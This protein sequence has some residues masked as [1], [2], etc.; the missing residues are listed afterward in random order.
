MAPPSSPPSAHRGLS[1]QLLNS[2]RAVAGF[3]FSSSVRGST[4]CCRSRL[5][6]SPVPTLCTPVEAGSQAHAIDFTHSAQDFLVL[7][8]QWIWGLLLRA[9]TMKERVLRAL[10]RSVFT[11][12]KLSTFVPTYCCACYFL[13]LLANLYLIC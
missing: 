8:S 12:C 9:A 3:L 4:Y 5:P 13:K 2:F 7:T 6:F 1:R 11:V 10:I